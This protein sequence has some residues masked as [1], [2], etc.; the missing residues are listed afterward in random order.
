MV[1]GHLQ[2]FHLGHATADE[3]VSSVENTPNELPKKNMVRFFSGLPQCHKV[4]RRKLKRELSPGMV[5]IGECSLHKVRNT[6]SAVSWNLLRL[7]STTTSGLQRDML[8]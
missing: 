7:I 4:L 3:L 6:F 8:T 5:D 1:V 2:S